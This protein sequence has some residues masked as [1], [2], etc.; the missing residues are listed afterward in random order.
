[1][2]K[3]STSI[4][5]IART[6][7]SFS[8]SAEQFSLEQINVAANLHAAQQAERAANLLQSILSRLDALGRDGIHDLIRL[9]ATRARKA[10]RLKKARAAAKRRRTIAA[11][12]AGQ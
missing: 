3:Q 1:M 5:D 8:T 6:A 10:D 11:R 4:K 2:A 9:E 7:W 12:K